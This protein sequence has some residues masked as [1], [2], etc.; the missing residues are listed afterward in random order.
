MANRTHYIVLDGA[1]IDEASELVAEFLG[2]TKLDRR[3]VLSARL[4][5]ESALMRLG[6]HAGGDTHATLTMDDHLGKP[7]LTV[8]A[9]GERFDPRGEVSGSDWESALLE[10]AGIRPSYAYHGGHNIISLSCPRP[11]MGST[12]KATVAIALGIAISQL[13][14]RFLSP[15]LRT[16]LLDGLFNPVF[17]IFVGMLGGVAGPMV[18]LSVAWG[19]CGIGDMAALGKSGK[20]LVSRYM[21]ANVLA[22]IFSLAVGIPAFHLAA[23]GAGGGGNV[24]QEMVTMLL[25][26]LPTNIVKPFAE[27]NTLQIIVL[28]V[29]VGVAALALGDRSEFVR[30]L[31]RQLNALIQFLMEQLCR[32]LPAFIVVMMVVQSWSG[33][34]GTLLS[35][36]YPIVVASI[37]QVIFFVAMVLRASI[38]NKVPVAKLARLLMP[39]LI[40]SFTT[41]SSS[42]AFGTVMSTCED[43]FGVDKD[44]TAFGVPL[45][46][47]LCKPMMPIIITCFMLFAAQAY[48]VG[49]NVMWYVR[50]GISSLLYA[51]AV[52][53][54][55]GGMLACYS[56]LL[57]GLGIPLDALAVVT[58]LDLLLDNISTSGDVGGLMLEV[59]SAANS[60]G[61]LDRTKLDATTE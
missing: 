56:M 4:A 39:S 29:A 6:E 2:M 18:F 47:V 7:R 60:L 58:A 31:L 13:G 19:I 16:T 52:P 5:F 57:A 9:K 32:L 38:S 35:S 50:L 33:T 44:Q 23:G 3:S 49:A 24:L 22:A 54:V 45:G 27:G 37:A 21:R 40:I 11:P 61:K 8:S 59:L 53:P 15:E 34:M 48:G 41:A 42:A 46:M 20:A 36:W 25:G 51:V 26:L 43:D 14:L 10:A 28:A 17:D 1:G 55:P 30:K 12:L